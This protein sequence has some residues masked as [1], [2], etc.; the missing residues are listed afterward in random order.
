MFYNR[1]QCFSFFQRRPSHGASPSRA[2]S[3]WSHS[4]NSFTHSLF[5]TM[6]LS[7]TA[8]TRRG[9]FLM[10]HFLAD[11]LAVV[12]QSPGPHVH[13]ISHPRNIF[14]LQSVKDCVWRTSVDLIANFRARILEEFR[15]MAKGM[16][17]RPSTEQDRCLHVISA[18]TSS[19]LRCTEAY[20]KVVSLGA[21]SK[22]LHFC[23]FGYHV[24]NL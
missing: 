21:V 24:M 20:V 8:V 10:K 2:I 11:G 13:L 14:L 9:H 6:V 5:N 22:R 1:L 12:D 4:W 7:H 18:T 17:I 15:S 3:T 19:V 23:V 16:L